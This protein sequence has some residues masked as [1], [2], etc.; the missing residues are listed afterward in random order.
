MRFSNYR[1]QYNILN[2][3]IIRHILWFF[4]IASIVL[5]FCTIPTLNHYHIITSITIRL[6]LIN[7]LFPLFSLKILCSL[8]ML[9]FMRY[10]SCT[11][12]NHNF[13]TNIYNFLEVWNFWRFDILKRFNSIYWFK[14]AWNMTMD[15]IQFSMHWIFS[16]V[17]L[18][19]WAELRKCT[20]FGFD[21]FITNIKCLL[22]LSQMYSKA[23][24]TRFHFSICF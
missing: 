21:F 13:F 24:K 14:F 8:N 10:W 15:K 4:K 12:V 5:T 23:L 7:Q 11:G 6:E 19:L 17:F 1:Y 2:D 16:F 22:Y 3:I 18:I 9:H 20:L